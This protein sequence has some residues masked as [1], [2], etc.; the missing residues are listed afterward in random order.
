MV[1][2]AIGHQRGK[3][4]GSIFIID[5]HGHY[6]RGSWLYYRGVIII[7]IGYQ[8]R[9]GLWKLIIILIGH[10]IRTRRVF[11]MVI[12]TGL[13]GSTFWISRCIG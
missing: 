1:I 2:I 8:R 9:K 13:T 3:G 4:T 12:A 11:A 6:G 5:R 7:T 10:V